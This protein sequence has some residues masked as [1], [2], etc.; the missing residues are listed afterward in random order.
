MNAT[1]P[2]APRA[3]RL[4]GLAAAALLLGAL[5]PAPARADTC[6]IGF[7]PGGTPAIDGARTGVEWDDA[8]VLQSGGGCLN[9]LVG[10]QAGNAERTVR[11]YSKSDNLNLYLLFEVGDVTNALGASGSLGE[12]IILHLDPNHSRDVIL[13]AGG[14]DHR[15]VFSHRWSTSAGLQRDHYTSQTGSGLCPGQ[16]DWLGPTPWPA[17]DVVMQPS[18]AGGGAGYTV[19]MKFSLASLGVAAPLATDIGLAFAIVNDLNASTFYSGTRF[20]ES[21]PFTTN[22]N[23]LSSDETASCNDWLSPLAWGGGYHDQAPGD[24]TF[25][26]APVYWQATAVQA[27]YCTGATGWEYY[28]GHPCEVRVRATVLNPGGATKRNLL[29][30]WGDHDA[31]TVRWTFMD[32]RIGV[33]IPTGGATETSAIWD[34]PAGLAAHPCIRVYA[35]PNS[36]RGDFTEAQIRALAQA[37]HTTIVDLETKYGLQPIHSAQRNISRLATGTNC[38]GGLC[39]TSLG[40]SREPLLAWSLA[41]LPSLFG[42][43]RLSAQRTGEGPR[44]TL[45]GNQVIWSD[46]DR[47]TFGA[48][49]VGVQVRTYGYQHPRARQRTPYR[50]IEALGGALQLVPAEILMRQQQQKLTF[51]VTAPDEA[52]YTVLPVIDQHVPQ[53][54]TVRL[55]LRAT[56]LEFEKGE[57]RRLEGVLVYGGGTPAGGTTPPDSTPPGGGGKK[58]CPLGGGGAAVVLVGLALLRLVRHPRATE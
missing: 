34:A 13:N 27:L 48:R 30:L 3:A 16:N 41:R 21:L 22:A 43:A 33:N 25:D 11:V 23:M 24:V 31:G 32:L 47:R 8:S 10:S 1:T 57:T 38:P 36:F 28:P 49:N 19:E 29:Y 5:A 20:P 15:Y 51:N 35:L 50:I 52:R 6:W 46:A 56:P 37:P 12:M 2:G 26:H 9:D 42:P 14:A 45:R 7:R 58:G 4:A 18:L 53:G 54:M 39:P 55:D 17:A 40:D 44:D